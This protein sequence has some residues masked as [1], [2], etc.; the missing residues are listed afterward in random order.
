MD[1]G[2]YYSRI[3]TAIVHKVVI[4]NHRI[5]GSYSSLVAGVVVSI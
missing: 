3:L 5:G 1:V 2:A 4:L